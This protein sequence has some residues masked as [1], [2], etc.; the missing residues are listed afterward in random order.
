MTAVGEEVPRGNVDLLLDPS[1]GPWF[2]GNL[3]SNTGNWLYNVVAAVVVFQLSGSALL[4]G[5][6]SVSQFLPLVLLS[7]WTGAMS[8]RLDRRWLL[9]IGQTIAAASAL[10]LAVPTALHGVETLPSVWPVLGA[11]LGIGLG[12]AIAKP[13]QNALVPLLVDDPDLESAVSLTALTFSVGRAL[14]PGAAGAVLLTVGAGTAFVLNA[15]SFLVLIAALLVVQPRAHDTSAAKDRSAL[16]GLRHVRDDRQIV[17]LL[18]AVA[19]AGFV[20]DPVVTLSPPLADLFGGGDVLVAVMVSSFGV[21]AIPGALLSGRLQ[22]RFGG[23]ASAGYGM[24]MSFMGLVFVAVAWVP[25]VAVAGFALSGGGS[26]LAATS[27]TSVLQRYVAEAFRGRVMALWAVA[28]LGNRP[29]AALLDGAA[30]D[31]FGPRYALVLPAAVAVVGWWLAGSCARSRHP[32]LNESQRTS[33]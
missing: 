2:W 14:G 28:F 22:R 11:S 15:A 33:V 10:A 13:A 32:V 29:L 19:T 9:V 25:A 4:V 26:T 1:F 21:A 27:F 8:D 5:L 3:V 18:L 6:V 24:A 30:A 20:A 23:L 17:L 16:G 31:Q 7:P 12:Q